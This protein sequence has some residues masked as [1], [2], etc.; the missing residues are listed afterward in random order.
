VTSGNVTEKG[1]K[2]KEC[3]LRFLFSDFLTANKSRVWRGFLVL[4]VRCTHEV[5]GIY[6]FDFWWA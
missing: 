3:T 2:R 1:R 6:V 4:E 5:F